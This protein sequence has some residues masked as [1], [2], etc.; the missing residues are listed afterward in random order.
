MSLTKTDINCTDDY[1]FYQQK[2][3]LM[4]FGVNKN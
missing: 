2:K 4:V 1:I 3:T